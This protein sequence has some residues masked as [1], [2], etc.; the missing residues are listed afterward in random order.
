[1]RRRFECVCHAST[2]RIIESGICLIG[3]VTGDTFFTLESLPGVI[4]EAIRDNVLVVFRTLVSYF[5]RYKLGHFPCPLSVN[6]KC[7]HHNVQTQLFNFKEITSSKWLHY[8]PLPNPTPKG[9]L[10][11]KP[12]IPI[13]PAKQTNPD[14]EKH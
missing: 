4:A 11:H 14:T 1:M 2:L 13:W 6:C 7:R 3:H 12:Y 9:K 8:T 10:P 5:L